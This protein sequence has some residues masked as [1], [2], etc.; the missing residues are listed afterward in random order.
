MGKDKKRKKYAQEG[1]PWADINFSSYC[2]S[3]VYVQY[4][5]HVKKSI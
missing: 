5:T 1:T 4:N 3:T 2:A